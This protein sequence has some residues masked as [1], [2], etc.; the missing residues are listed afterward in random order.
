MWTVQEEIEKAI[1]ALGLPKSRIRRCDADEALAIQQK[2][3]DIFVVGTPRVWWLALRHPFQSHV[4]DETTGLDFLDYLIPH[5]D[6]RCW[7]IPESEESLLP[8]Y[9]ADISAVKDILGECPFF[10]YYLVGKNY[11]WLLLEN[12]HNEVIVVDLTKSP[13][14]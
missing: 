3:R 1:A 5:N 10:E 13:E 12:D 7:F 4:F 9:D 8:V 6:Q 11:D 2:A 14:S